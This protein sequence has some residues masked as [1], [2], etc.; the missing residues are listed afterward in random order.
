MQPPF[1]EAGLEELM[2]QFSAPPERYQAVMAELCKILGLPYDE[3]METNTLDW[4]G[5]DVGFMHQGMMNPDGM[6]L[7]FDL[8]ELPKD[9]HSERELFKTILTMN[10]VNPAGMGA[11]CLIPDNEHVGFTVSYQFTE[12]NATTAQSLIELIETVTQQLKLMPSLQ[13]IIQGP[14]PDGAVM[15]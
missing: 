12:D 13:S 10:L 7:F 2:K 9:K 15:G 5:T 8:G 1:D 6:K 3:V 4:K 11:F 14:I